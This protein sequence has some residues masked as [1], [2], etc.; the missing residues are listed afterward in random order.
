V[1]AT[2][3]PL[4][5]P[6]AGRRPPLHIAHRGGAALAAE[7]TML[8]FRRAVEMHRTDMLELDLQLTGDDEL[9]V[10]HDDTL[11]RCTDGAGPVR[12]HT[13]SEIARLDAGFRFT[14]D[15]GRTFPHRGQG[16]RV[17]RWIEVL[18]AFPDLLI[19][20]ELK[21]AGGPI[22]EVFADLLRAEGAVGR[23][24][25]GSE[26]DALA[27]RLHDR[28]PDACHF[29]PREAGA[30]FIMAVRAGAEPPEDPRYRVLDMPL[31]FGGVGLVD[32][33]LV[34]VAAARGRW[35][36]VWTVD[37][38]VEMRRLISLG[39]GGIMTDRPDRLRRILDARAM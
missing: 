4:P 25:C 11:D 30:T 20:V 29:Y 12:E 8:A 6:F 35:I 16:A 22:D 2:A 3:P 37:E 15:A 18:R 27:A 28:L 24:C 21:P 32:E 13:F 34:E 23:V 5:A 1:T 39:V 7:N 9:V 31:T 38:E 36:N 33:R 10:L 17:P 19:N 14:A 26:D